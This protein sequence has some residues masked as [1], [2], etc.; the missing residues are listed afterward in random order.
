VEGPPQR[1][2]VW[3]KARRAGIWMNVERVRI[4]SAPSFYAV[5]TSGRLASALS[6]TENLRHRVSIPLAIRAFGTM[7]EAEDAPAFTEA[8][9]RLRT[10][11]GLFRLSEGAV[12]VTR[13]TLFRT[14]VALPATLTEGQ[15]VVRV[16]LSRGG[17]VLDVTQTAVAVHKSGLEARMANLARDQPIAYGL[18]AVALAVGAGWGASAAFRFLRS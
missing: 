10:E 5:A 1:L 14:S 11:A 13:E 16:L 7:A 6:A 18:L 12:E 4:A 2:A 15:Y 3:R 9:I 17:Q 8:L